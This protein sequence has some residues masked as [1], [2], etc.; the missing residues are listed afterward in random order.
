MRLRRRF[1]FWSRFAGN[2]V[3][4][5]VNFQTLLFSADFPQISQKEQRKTA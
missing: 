1:A 3:K 5:S 4:N 2:S